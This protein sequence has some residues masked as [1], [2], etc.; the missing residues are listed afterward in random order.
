MKKNLKLYISAALAILL[1]AG[2]V[3]FPPR[4]LACGGD[5]LTSEDGDI[6]N[7]EEVPEESILIAPSLSEEVE[8]DK[9]YF[10]ADETLVSEKNANHSLFLAGSDVSSK[11]S[12]FGLGFLAGNVVNAAG[13]YEYG[14]FAGSSVEVTGEVEN[15]LFVAGNTVKIDEAASIGRDVYA[16]GNILTISANLNGK[17]FAAGNRLV[18]NNVTI[19]GDFDAEFSSI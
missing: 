8:K 17:V 15:D 1:V 6:T 11:D 18:L 10:S 4:S 5:G 19:D 13:T 3:A 9:E 7:C 14:F 16:A 12:V 2:M